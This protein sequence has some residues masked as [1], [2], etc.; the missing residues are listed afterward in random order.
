MH[1]GGCC[2]GEQ[3]LT[4]TG[5]LH[6]FTLGKMEHDG[7]LQ[8]VSHPVRSI[9]P[10]SERFICWKIIAIGSSISQMTV[11][12]RCSS[13]TLQTAREV[14]K[15]LCSADFYLRWIINYDNL[16]TVQKPYVVTYIVLER[17]NLDKLS[18]TFQTQNACLD[19]GGWSVVLILALLVFFRI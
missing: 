5:R 7:E 10:L 12:I 4:V 3:Q 14:S 18:S 11:N 2:S 8:L 9:A 19:E 17:S 15:R 1:A 13:S 6:F 16:H